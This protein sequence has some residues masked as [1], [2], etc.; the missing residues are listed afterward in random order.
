MTRWTVDVVLDGERKLIAFPDARDSLRWEAET[1]QNFFREPEY[2]AELF[3]WLAWS[4]LERTGQYTGKPEEFR[5][6]LRDLTPRAFD[7]AE[8]DP[9]PPAATTG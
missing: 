1:G 3:T 5:E 8:V 2:T 9:T 4:A 7:I 6:E